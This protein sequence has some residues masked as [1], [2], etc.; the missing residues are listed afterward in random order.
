MLYREYIQNS[1]D[2]IDEISFT[3]PS[4]KNKAKIEINIDGRNRRIIINDNGAGI[5][6]EDAWATLFNIGKSNK[7]STISRGFRGIG[8]LGGIGYCDELRFKTKAS[9]ESIYTES[10]WNTKRLR[11]IISNSSLSKNTTDIIK[12]VTEFE[13][14]HYSGPLKDHFFIVEMFNV[15]STKD[16]CLDVPEVKSYIS[17]VAPVPFDVNKFSYS[18]QIEKKLIENVPLYDVYK[19]YVNGEQIFKPYQDEVNISSKLKDKIKNINFFELKNDEEYL[20]FGWI[21]KLQYLGSI[22]RSNLFDCIRIRCGN[23]LVGDKNLLSEFFREERFNSYLIGELYI[24]NDKLI[25][26]SRRDDFEYNLHKEKLYNCFIKEVGI[27]YSKKIRDASEERSRIKFNNREINIKQ[28]AE[29]IIKHG[30]YSANQKRRVINDLLKIIKETDNIDN[31]SI[32]DLL[33]NVNNSRFYFEMDHN[34]IKRK[35]KE[36]L[37]KICET[38][39]ESCSNKSEAQKVIKSIIEKNIF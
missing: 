22:N 34:N 29:Q 18:E 6:G 28:E 24:A 10:V 33:E 11:E 36:K 7:L 12:E 17:Q 19:I 5:K 30:F 32:N 14:K 1:V 26:N 15:S 16:I 8:R 27:P 13:Q 9:G 35:D 25:P 37:K 21:A 31:T 38:I 2:S 20:A 23:I 4:H 3:K 39:Y